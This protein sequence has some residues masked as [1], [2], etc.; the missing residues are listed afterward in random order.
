MTNEITVLSLKTR[1]ENTILELESNQILQQMRNDES[2]A[3]FK[4]QHIR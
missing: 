2:L 3:E 4:R 1:L